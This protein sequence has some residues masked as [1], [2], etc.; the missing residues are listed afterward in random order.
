MSEM[1]AVDIQ[2]TSRD[3]LA[4]LIK[5]ALGR[6]DGPGA[7]I[8]TEEF[9]RRFPNHL[10][11][12]FDACEAA[13]L[14]DDRTAADQLMVSA[15]ARFP[16]QSWPT[17]YFAYNAFRQREWDVAAG[18]YLVGLNKFPG[19]LPN[20][21]GLAETLRRCGLPFLG[22]QVLEIAIE[23]YP[24]DQE[25]YAARLALVVETQDWGRVPDLFRELVDKF[26]DAASRALQG[27][28]AVG[29]AAGNSVAQECIS[30]VVEKTGVSE[31][32]LI[33]KIELFLDAEDVKS[34]LELWD[35]NFSLF[36][37][38]DQT[39]RTAAR[40]LMAGLTSALPRESL[41]KV[42]R[43]FLHQPFVE[44][45][46]WHPFIVGLRSELQISKNDLGVQ[47]LKSLANECLASEVDMS[48]CALFTRVAFGDNS[49]FEEFAKLADTG[50]SYLQKA[51]I[52]L[53]LFA[54]E[55][56]STQFCVRYIRR[57]V[58]AGYPGTESN[59]L[60]QLAGSDVA[61]CLL[62]LATLH[63]PL[64]AEELLARLRQAALVEPSRA[65]SWDNAVGS[66]AQAY[67]L[68]GDPPAVIFRRG[69]KLRIALCIS[70]QLRGYR[71]AHASWDY[72]GL[73]AH[74]VHRTVHT[75]HNVGRRFPDNQWH[76]PRAFSGAFAEA[77]L[78]ASGREGYD[79]ILRRYPKLFNVFRSRQDAD[80]AQVRATFGTDDVV[81]EEDE[82]QP[83]AAMHNQEK[84]LYKIERC[85]EQALI[86]RIDYDLIIRMRPDKML[87][88][89]F[90]LDW[91][92]LFFESQ[93][94]R[95]IYTDIG[96]FNVF[97]YGYSIGDQ[98]AVGIAEAMTP[99]SRTWSFS[100]AAETRAAGWLPRGP[101][102]HTSMAYATF[103]A[104]VVVETVEG[105]QLGDL[106]SDDPL[107]SAEIRPLIL[108]DMGGAPRDELDRILLNACLATVEA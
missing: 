8:C 99:Y 55:F 63:D 43:Y 6:G 29:K 85:F 20:G 106:I 13:R 36:V 16:D 68:D 105:A 93:R 37:H 17:T 28:F 19:H 59:P 107:T 90:E 65:S 52:W 89:P 94:K 2:F 26:P 41:R 66:V 69:D 96:R 73:A 81:F 97:G 103:I 77:L 64:A 54:P 100:T 60:P 62:L 40:I 3:G 34:S 7:R 9:L 44:H 86:R 104:G 71:R 22:L 24:A 27:I 61:R 12:Y 46:S 47:A 5:A 51:N 1:L 75:W 15:M 30:I 18:R 4:D 70:G 92:R 48:A 45:S 42:V 72:L 56:V 87:S 32:I 88:A 95:K 35:D 108:A 31:N 78:L 74:D 50:L 14:C 25:I 67:R 53:K 11:G 38:S 58:D 91:N 33:T 39:N 57:Y 82:A 10:P 102:A 80:P 49:N 79:T 98:F 76:I 101:L 83:F 21:L 84:M 23:K